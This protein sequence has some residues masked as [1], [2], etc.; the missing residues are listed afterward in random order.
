MSAVSGAAGEVLPIPGF[1]TAGVDKGICAKMLEEQRDVLG[2][3]Q[4]SLTEEAN[5]YN[6]QSDKFFHRLHESRKVLT[7]NVLSSQTFGRKEGIQEECFQ[8]S[9]ND[10]QDTGDQRCCHF[11]QC[12]LKFVGSPHWNS[13]VVWQCWSSVLCSHSVCWE[14]N[15]GE[16]LR[17][18]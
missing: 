14:G 13:R 1:S 11:N 10:H 5:K 2:I 16:K 7:E 12:E 18:C 4:T 9:E 15:A 6:L 17:D 8:P 3:S